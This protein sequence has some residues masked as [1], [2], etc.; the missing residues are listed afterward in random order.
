MD[1]EA[2]DMQ[3]LVHQCAQEIGNTVSLM[4]QAIQDDSFDIE[5]VAQIAR[6]VVILADLAHEM[7]IVSNG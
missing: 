2:L 5:Q 6:W 4:G 1:G 7:R 3:S